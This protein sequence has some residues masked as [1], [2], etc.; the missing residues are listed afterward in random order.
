MKNIKKYENFLLKANFD[1][2]LKTKQKFGLNVK[3]GPT[4]ISHFILLFRIYFLPVIVFNHK[5]NAT[6]VHHI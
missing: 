6:H 3:N 2:I 4:L 5:M 1:L